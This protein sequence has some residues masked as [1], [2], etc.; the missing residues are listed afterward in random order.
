M[1]QIREVAEGRAAL[2]GLG[3]AGKTQTAVE[4]AHRYLDEYAYT[5][6][7]IADSRDSIVSGYV[8]MATLL[9][10]P[11]ADAQEQMLAF[12]RLSNAGSARTRGWLLSV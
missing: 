6:W 1:A 8:K 2:S 7:A 5:L 11:E 3:G 4:Y 12:G 10:L 9:E